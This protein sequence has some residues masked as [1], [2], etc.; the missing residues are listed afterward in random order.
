MNH[1]EPLPYPQKQMSVEFISIP[2]ILNPPKILQ[3]P[4]RWG[5][6]HGRRQ[7]AANLMNALRINRT[8][9]VLPK[10]RARRLPRYI[11]NAG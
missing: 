4:I 8:E 2:P 11:V 1:R 7:S 6:A 9:I 10:L 3:L 5:M